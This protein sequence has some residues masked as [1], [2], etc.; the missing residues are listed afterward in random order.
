MLL[1]IN[2]VEHTYVIIK[3]YFWLKR[4]THFYS[5]YIYISINIYI[6][7]TGNNIFHNIIND[8]PTGSPGIKIYFKIQIYI[9]LKNIILIYRLSLFYPQKY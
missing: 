2:I 9:I 5:L 1:N 6:N 7:I 3:N 4:S 8:I